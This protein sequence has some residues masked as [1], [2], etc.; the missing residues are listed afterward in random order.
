MAPNRSRSNSNA[1]PRSYSPNVPRQAP[2]QRP[3][4]GSVQAAPSP[5]VTPA[6]AVKGPRAECAPTPEPSGD[7][8]MSPASR[9]YKNLRVLRRY[10]PHI[11]SI[12][13]QFAH[14]TLYYQ[15]EEG[16]KYERGGY[17]GVMFFFER[18]IEPTYGFFI[19]NRQGMNDYIRYLHPTDVIDS[20]G[21]LVWV[22][23]L[24]AKGKSVMG[25]EDKTAGLWAMPMDVRDSLGDMMKRLNDCIR[26]GQ[27][28]PEEYRYGPDRIAPQQTYFD[29]LS[30]S[31]G[32]RDPFMGVT[33]E[34][35]TKA[36]TAMQS[37][38]KAKAKADAEAKAN[39]GTPTSLPA[40]RSQ[41]SELDQLFSKLA[42]VTP[43]PP[44]PT[45]PAP[46]QPLSGLA[47]LN[48]MFASVSDSAIPQSNGKLTLQQ[49]GFAPAVST[50]P[51]DLEIL[52]PKP[53]AA[54]LPQ[55]LTADVIHELMGLPLSDSRS[56]SR[57]SVF[58]PASEHPRSPSSAGAYGSKERGYF[59]DRG[60]DDGVSEASTSQDLEN[61]V[62]T[63]VLGRLAP[64]TRPSFLSAASSGSV[65]SLNG[66]ATPRARMEPLGLASPPTRARPGAAHTVSETQTL[67]L[68]VGMAPGARKPVAKVANGSRTVSAPSTVRVPFQ[69]G[70]ELWPN[71][72]SEASTSAS[73]NSV[74]GEETDGDEVVEL[75]FSE[76]GMLDDMRAFEAKGSG[77]GRK[78]EGSIRPKEKMNGTQAIGAQTNGSI[79]ARPMRQEKR[80]SKK[81][82]P[83]GSAKTGNENP[84][85]PQNGT[86]RVNTDS[87]P[88]TPSSGSIVKSPLQAPIRPAGV[89]RDVAEGSL[90]A[91]LVDSGL[92]R[93]NGQ[94]LERNAFMREVLMLIHT[95]KSFVDRLYQT[96]QNIVSGP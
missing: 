37:N 89:L 42:P 29:R 91:A 56:A 40:P 53:S 80:P 33:D 41:M 83:E 66:D 88:S 17:E 35:R 67:A 28:Y 86:M 87:R 10:D 31:N 39:A 13:D 75:D 47:L 16:G 54:A 65:P 21:D 71:G 68:G 73:S 6:R 92:L 36:I 22:A 93:A 20:V 25:D 85:A 48:T 12:F 24:D 38:S 49:L 95:D 46:Q 3:R 60:E 72:A 5:T 51:H 84:I 52:S 26:D 55:I 11:V 82:N 63:S 59:A 18:D 43:S 4:R 44:D 45:P 76:I 58:A 74:D 81:Q 69:S 2:R 30:Q 8:G 77:R 78:A 23:T 57:T 34:M 14:V 62:N 79:P 15:D 96:Y 70:A 61:D 94:V 50:P 32:N 7:I 90:R 1:N 27:P 64:G 19:L 9:Y